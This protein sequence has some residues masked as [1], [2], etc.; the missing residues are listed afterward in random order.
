[1]VYLEVSEVVHVDLIRLPESYVS[2]GPGRDP[3]VLKALRN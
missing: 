3:G 2:D 1:M